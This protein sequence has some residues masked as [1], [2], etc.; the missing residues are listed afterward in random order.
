MQSLRRN[1]R[2][3][4]PDRQVNDSL[5]SRN[6]AACSGTDNAKHMDA[7]ALALHLATASS[8]S[9]AL[10]STV[11]SDQESMEDHLTRSQELSCSRNHIATGDT[12]LGPPPPY[13]PPYDYDLN[14]DTANPELES[15]RS[16]VAQQATTA[17]DSAI[18]G[19]EESGH[20]DDPHTHLLDEPGEKSP[21]GRYPWMRVNRTAHMRTLRS[22]RLYTAIGLVVVL[23]TSGIL[24]YLNVFFSPLTYEA[25]L[26][27]PRLPVRNPLHDR[28][29]RW[30]RLMARFIH[31][32]QHTKTS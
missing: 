3:A 28:T 23:L 4:T 17:S 16:P 14:V 29:F 11:A 32:T 20:E 15:M 19:A 6:A 10:P 18:H 1:E 8:W 24:G 7:A 30:F 25:K 2:Q 13:H 27:P 26:T 31:N 9:D 12:A 21:G 22:W 5:S